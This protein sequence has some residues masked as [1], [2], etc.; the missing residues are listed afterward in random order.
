MRRT[1]GI[2]TNANIAKHRVLVGVLGSET[3]KH[4]ENV[5]NLLGS[6]GPNIY[7]YIYVLERVTFSN[8]NPPH[9]QAVFLSAATSLPP[10]EEEKNMKKL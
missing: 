7:I 1:L 3:L 9:V 10:P 4:M 2:E 8:K 5:L 6:F